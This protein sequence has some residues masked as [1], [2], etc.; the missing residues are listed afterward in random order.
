LWFNV[1]CL[2]CGAFSKTRRDEAT[3]LIVKTVKRFS[4]SRLLKSEKAFSASCIQAGFFN[5]AFFISERNRESN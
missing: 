4:F 1:G 5:P 2:Q 3:L